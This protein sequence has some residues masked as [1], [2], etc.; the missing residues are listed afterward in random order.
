M[1][2]FD[3]S[4]SGKDNGTHQNCLAAYNQTL[5]GGK[6]E[7]GRSVWIDPAGVRLICS[8]LQPHMTVLE[9]GSGGST[10]LF[11]QFVRAWHSV[12]HNKWW[13]NKVIWLS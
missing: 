3:E 8:L 6:F 5:V 4:S 2:E 10:A 9:F 12:E 7:R 11:S 13:A 1:F